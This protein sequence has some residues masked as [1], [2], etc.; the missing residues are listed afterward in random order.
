[1]LLLG[2]EDLEGGADEREAAGEG[3][4]EHHADAVPVAGGGRGLA[5]GL[6]GG[7][8]RGGP[9]DAVL[10]GGVDRRGTRSLTRPK[11][12]MTTRPCG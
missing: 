5:G 9:E 11:S 3:L 7:H 8:V 12:R 2:G 1:V 10:E 6:L 4:V